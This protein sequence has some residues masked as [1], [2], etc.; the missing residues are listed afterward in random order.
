MM[1][2]LADYPRNQRVATQLRDDILDYRR[3]YPRRPVHLV[4]HSGGGG[5]AVLAVEQLPVEQPVSSVVLLAPAISPGYDL[6]QALRRTQFGIFNYYSELD[7]VL[8][9][10]GTM[11]AGTIDRRHAQAAGAVG[12]ETPKGLDSAG[13]RLYGRKLHQIKW[14]PEMRWYSHFGGHMDWT[15]RPFVRRYLAVLIDSINTWRYDEEEFALQEAR[16][17]FRE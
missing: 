13:V 6:S 3:E 9:R 15:H 10:A 14:E 2:N 11:L 17:S 1:I 4:G 12:F 5:L 16:A 7:A 8:L